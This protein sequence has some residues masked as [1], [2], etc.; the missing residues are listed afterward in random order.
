[1]APSQRRRLARANPG[2]Q[3][4]RV[5]D[6]AIERDLGVRDQRLHLVARED[7]R[8]RHSG[9]LSTSGPSWRSFFEIP[10]V[11]LPARTLGEPLENPGPSEARRGYA[12]A[13]FGEPF[14][15][16]TSRF[17]ADLTTSRYSCGV[18]IP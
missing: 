10:G 17:W 4:Q 3:L 15:R 11:A 1:V 18:A 5:D 14:A 13:Q 7:R 9:S 8:G 6:P 2:E 16:V 12:R